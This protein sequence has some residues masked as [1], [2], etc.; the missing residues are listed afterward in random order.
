MK[1]LTGDLRN[2]H[3]DDDFAELQVKIKDEITKDDLAKC[4]ND[5]SYLLVNMIDGTYFNPEQNE[6]KPIKCVLAGV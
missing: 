6:W 1:Y 2:L 4:R 3:S 5:D